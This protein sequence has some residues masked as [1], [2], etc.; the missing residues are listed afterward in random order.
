MGMDARNHALRLASGDILFPLYNENYWKSVFLLSKDGAKTWQPA[1]II[2]THPGNIQPT[3]VQFDDGS[4]MAL[5][6]T[7]G[8]NGQDLA[9]LEQGR[10]HD[11]DQGG[12]DRA[13]QSEC[14]H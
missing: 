2:P 8:S 12:E 10:G 11:L 7:H 5:M 14:G 13:P 4:L 9:G 6:R 3:V 1:G